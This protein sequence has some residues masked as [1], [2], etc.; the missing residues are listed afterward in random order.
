[1]AAARVRG[2]LIPNHNKQTRTEHTDKQTIHSHCIPSKPQTDCKQTA[3]A[4]HTLLNHKQHDT[5]R[6]GGTTAVSRKRGSVL[7]Q[8]MGVSE[9]LIGVGMGRTL[10]I[11]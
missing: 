7:R 1:M 8:G 6:E 5:S 9:G 11:G 4:S 3:R 2:V 10:W